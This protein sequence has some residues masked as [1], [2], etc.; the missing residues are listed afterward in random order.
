LVQKISI[1]NVE[2]HI[3]EIAN[4]IKAEIE[5]EMGKFGF[6]IVNLSVESINVPQEDTDALNAIF[7]KKAEFEQLGD[8][9]YRTARGYDV[10]KARPITKAVASP[11]WASA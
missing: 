6:E 9:R 10:L 7:H 2:P 4:A 8:T 1:F 11:R 5:P 3:E